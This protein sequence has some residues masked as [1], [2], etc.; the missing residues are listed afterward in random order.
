MN[1]F[2]RMSGLN[3]Y[4]GDLHNHNEI[5]YGKGSC[6]RA[7]ALA[8]NALDFLAFTPHGWWPDQPPQDPK[9][10]KYH[11]DGFE[12]VAR[13]WAEVEARANAATED[14]RFVAFV[15]V[16]W[17]SCRWGDYHLLFPGPKGEICRAEDHA[18]LVAFARERG[19]LAI[20]HHVGY[21]EGWRGADWAA[22]DERRFPVAEVYSEHGTTFEAPSH[23]GMY[24]HSMGGVSRE[25]TVLEQ[26]RRGRVVGLL[27]STDNH[28]GYP[29]CYGEGLAG[30]WAPELTRAALWKALHQRRTVAATGDRIAVRL[31]M[32]G[33]LMGDVVPAST[34]RALRVEVEAADEVDYVEL[35]KNGRPLHR[36]D[37]ASLRG[38]GAGRT[39]LRV[40]WGWDGLGSGAVTR[41]S[42][43]A[44]VSAGKVARAVP[45]FAGGAGLLD[46]VNLLHREGERAVR[47]EASTSRLNVWPCSSMVLELEAP[48]S[49]GLRVAAEGSREGAPFAFAIETSLDRLRGRDEWRA[50]SGSFSAPKLRVGPA[51]DKAGLSLDAAFEDLEPG[52]RDFYYVKVLQRNGHVAWGTPIWCRG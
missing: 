52:A 43:G 40:E 33:A 11:R 3:L 29:G 48:A 1:D 27:A 41:W 8:R 23:R 12:R 34:P 10:A 18:G 28:F 46:Q 4:W 14:G 47:A 49:A 51:L 9:V 38:P 32:G 16:E 26:L 22:N 42:V 21:R 31:S 36:W 17:H 30:I 5:G 37:G 2:R 50:I 44:E 24:S 25:Q 6:E 35:N 15:A 39:V 19:A 7:Y 45:C 20:P 13:R